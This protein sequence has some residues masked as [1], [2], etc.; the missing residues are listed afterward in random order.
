MNRV[1]VVGRSHMWL[2]GLQELLEDSDFDVKTQERLNDSVAQTGA[3]CVVVHLPDAQ[4]H[5]DLRVFREGEKNVPVLGVVD[6]VDLL[7]TTRALRAGATSVIA[8]SD[9]AEVAAHAVRAAAVSRS[10]LP[11]SVVVSM[12]HHVPDSDD[13]RSWIAPSQI[14]WLRAMASGSTVAEVAE[15]AGYSERAMFRQL[16][17]LYL[18]LGV[19]NR[20]EALLWAKQH[21]LLESTPT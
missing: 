2:R 4:A 12:A 16:R 6:S 11:S 3:L 15:D 10:S 19:N 13:I 9:A 17:I 21:G 8:D 1:V 14:S 18:R 20:T 5:S 7:S